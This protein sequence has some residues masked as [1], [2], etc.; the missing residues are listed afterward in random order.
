MIF[1]TGVPETTVTIDGVVFV[2]DSAVTSFILESI[3][4]HGPAAERLCNKDPLTL[5][6]GEYFNKIFPNSKWLFIVR[7]GRAVVHSV[8]KRLVMVAVMVLVLVMVVSF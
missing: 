7:D 3:V 2:I 5:K 4:Q 6:H 1:A 8:I